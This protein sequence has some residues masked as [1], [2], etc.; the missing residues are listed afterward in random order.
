MLR[1]TFAASLVLTATHE[2]CG[3]CHEIGVKT[4]AEILELKA[5][6]SIFGHASC[7]ACHTRHT[8]S[9]REAREPEPCATCHMEV[10]PHPPDAR[11]TR[12]TP[13]T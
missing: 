12:R 5:K 11:Q 1:V 7:D 8:F 9:A 4:E 6:G 2:T 10:A 13:L 3:G